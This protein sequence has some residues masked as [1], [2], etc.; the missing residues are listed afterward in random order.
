MRHKYETRAIVLSRAPSGESNTF[1][2]LLTPGL[3]LVR[4]RAQGLRRPGAK[5][6]AALTTLS[7][8]EVVL[9]RGREG[10][11][12]TGAVLAENWFVKMGRPLMRRR[13]ARVSGLL[14][15]LVVGE[16]QDVMLFPIVRGF[17]EA[18]ATIHDE[19]HAEAAEMLAVLRI[20]SALGFDAGDIPDG[21]SMFVLPILTSIE[22][23]R[24][25]YLARINR[26]IVASGL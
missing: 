18:L 22:A 20:L 2:T 15:R 10:W 8:S 3:G 11:R 1:I 19:A 6:A 14:T 12:I 13:A 17:F 24:A 7:E 23:E 25:H 5:L 4:A 9:V 26:G 21:S 16:T